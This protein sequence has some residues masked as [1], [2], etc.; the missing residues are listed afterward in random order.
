MRRPLRHSVVRVDRVVRRLVLARPL[1][2]RRRHCTSN[3]T[4]AA[5]ATGGRRT[6]RMTRSGVIVHARVFGGAEAV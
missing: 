4:A 1:P 3:A 5:S 2:R 6:G